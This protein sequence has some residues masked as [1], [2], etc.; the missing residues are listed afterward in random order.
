MIEQLEHFFCRLHRGFVL[1]FV[2]C[3]AF[4]A[5]AHHKRARTV[6]AGLILETDVTETL[7]K[8]IS[9]CMEWIDQCH[10]KKILA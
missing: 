10:E 2:W 9:V 4:V 3:G 6:P 1:R 5:L 8:P 7:S